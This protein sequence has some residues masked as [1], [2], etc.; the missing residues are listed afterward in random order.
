MEYPSYLGSLSKSINSISA[1]ISFF[2]CK[3]RILL[4]GGHLHT[5]FYPVDSS[6]VSTPIQKTGHSN[7]Q[8][9][10]R[11]NQTI[12]SQIWKSTT[13]EIGTQV[14]WAKQYVVVR[15]I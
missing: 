13:L 2:F 9:N 7:H 6:I 12:S 3:P 11:P 8:F 10:S 1:L 5:H 15:I 4:F 14:V